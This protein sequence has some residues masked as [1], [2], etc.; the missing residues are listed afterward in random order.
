MRELAE[1]AGAECLSVK[2][3]TI[4]AAA[5]GP[6][7]A[8]ARMA[9]IDYGKDLD[10]AAVESWL[11]E[12]DPKE[13]DRLWRMANETRRAHVGDDVWLR[14]LI[15]ISNN[16]A[17]RCAY[18]GIS[19]HMAGIAR[20]RMT[21]EDVLESAMKAVHYGFGTVVIQ[22]GEDPLIDG[23]WLASVIRTIKAE[24]GLAI[25]L[26]MGERPDA[27]LC[28]WREAGADRYLLRFE[29]SDDGLYGRIHPSLGDRRSDRRGQLRRM[30][31]MGFEIGTGVMIG[32]PGQTW[33]SLAA[34]ILLFCQYDMDMLGV[35]P[36]VEAPGTPLAGP[37]GKKLRR[38]AGREQVPADVP[39]TLKVIALT[40]LVCPT[41]NIPATT[42]L[43][44][45]DPGSGRMEGLR[46]GANVVMPN[47]TPPGYRALYSTYPGKP[48]AETRRKTFRAMASWLRWPN[49]SD[50]RI[51]TA[52]EE[53]AGIKAEIW[54]LDRTA[55]EGA[56]HRAGKS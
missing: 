53:M 9:K 43:E 8:V 21:A 50:A 25:T 33:A 20:Y 13:L 47:L 51:K 37:L 1:R 17:Q 52:D 7:A 56:G 24:T 41:S 2:P 31:D 49:G 54:S 26:S 15:E 23:P 3:M 35:G 22:A 27:D 39:T 12:D 36:F 38:D 6:V 4:S 32:I 14:G 19:S 18:C 42:A 48:G 34:D 5:A 55:S 29:T 46:K 10:A 30:R 11:R 28:A 40:R 44:A 45:M 16:C